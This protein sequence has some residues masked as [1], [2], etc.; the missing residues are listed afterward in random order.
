MSI[1]VPL[2]IEGRTDRT[3]QPDAKEKGKAQGV[4]GEAGVYEQSFTKSDCW[5]TRRGGRSMDTGSVD[6][7]AMRG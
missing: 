3:R 2:C 1:N 5:S 4:R 7:R 6:K